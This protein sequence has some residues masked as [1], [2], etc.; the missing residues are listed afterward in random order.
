MTLKTLLTW[1][2]APHMD[3]R[4]Q[5]QPAVEVVEVMKAVEAEQAVTAGV[6][7]ELAEASTP[8]S[9]AE[10]VQ[11]ELFATAPETEGAGV[12]VVAQDDLLE[13]FHEIELLPEATAA[14]LE[15]MCELA[16]EQAA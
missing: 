16:N 2:D 4:S 8:R 6:V 14:A 5:L 11:V 9:V 3:L 12:A 15:T 1:Q 10:L 7:A 13:G